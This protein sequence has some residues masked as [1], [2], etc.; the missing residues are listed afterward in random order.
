MDHCQRTRHQYHSSARYCS[1][2]YHNRF[3]ATK[4]SEITIEQNKQWEERV[5]VHIKCIHPSMKNQKNIISCWKIIRQGCPILFHAYQ[6]IK[7]FKEALPN[8]RKCSRN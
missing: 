2:L 4:E 6:L 8:I 7:H 5:A 3:H 1:F